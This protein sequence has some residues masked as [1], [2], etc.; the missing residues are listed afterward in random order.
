MKKRKATYGTIEKLT[1]IFE[2]AKQNN[3]LL[4]EVAQQINEQIS[5][6][7]WQQLTDATAFVISTNDRYFTDIRVALAAYLISFIDCLDDIEGQNWNDEDVNY[8]VNGYVVDD[9][10]I[11][12]QVTTGCT[13]AASVVTTLDDVL[14]AD[15]WF[16]ENWSDNPPGFR[17]GA[18][19][20]K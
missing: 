1:E 2:A 7:V 20:N 14:A 5:Y 12:Y 17:S 11:A 16:E 6:D 3:A 15:L 8:S 4:T 13:D 19:N 10:I 9:G 18:F